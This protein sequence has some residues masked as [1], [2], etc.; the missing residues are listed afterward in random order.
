[1]KIDARK[2]HSSAQEEKRRTAVKLW[3]KSHTFAEIASILEVSDTAIRKWVKAYQEH[4]L[5]GIKAKPRGHGKDVGRRLSPDQE[6]ALKKMI[7]DKLPDQLKLD[8]VL[9]TRK[10]VQE[11]IDQEYSIKMPIRTVG[12]YLK[13]WGFTPQKPAKR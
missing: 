3:K 13:R 2:L 11:L 1:M 4:G 5:S 8:Y 10:A 12:D 6:T 7:V 9:W